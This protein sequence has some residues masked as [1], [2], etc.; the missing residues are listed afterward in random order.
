MIK[1]IE[2]YTKTRTWNNTTVNGILEMIKE[3]IINYSDDK[4]DDFVIINETLLIIK[5]YCEN[6]D[7]VKGILKEFFY[8]LQKQ[9]FNSNIQETIYILN[10][11]LSI[12]ESCYLN[13]DEYDSY[14]FFKKY[15]NYKEYDNSIFLSLPKKIY[16][17]ADE[18]NWD[19]IDGIQMYLSCIKYLFNCFEDKKDEN[20]SIL[21]VQKFL[22]LVDLI[23]SEVNKV[24]TDLLSERTLPIEINMFLSEIKSTCEQYINHINRG[25]I[26]HKQN[27]IY[28]YDN[29]T[30]GSC[31]KVFM[32]HCDL[33]MQAFSGY[34]DV[35][36]KEKIK[37]NDLTDESYIML[38]KIILL[39]NESNWLLTIRH[40]FFP[41]K[42]IIKMFYYA[43]TIQNYD[44][45]VFVNEVYSSFKS[46]S[47]KNELLAIFSSKCIQILTKYFA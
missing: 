47:E 41:M 19:Y 20:V 22:K 4:I 16:G 5:T 31:L 43:I 46:L 3:N 28:K 39:I 6:N 15:M 12:I 7:E 32:I 30:L 40:I 11:F 35:I 29:K 42:V 18:N 34:D 1:Y 13:D 26:N 27:S 2:K 10:N 23:F 8:I 33:T 24:C 9:V 36:L 38:S 25:G 21:M 17:F 45:R 14:L 44:E 37:L